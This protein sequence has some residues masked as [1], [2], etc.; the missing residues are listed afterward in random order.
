MEERNLIKSESMPDLLGCNLSNRNPILDACSDQMNKFESK[1]ENWTGARILQIICEKLQNGKIP[2]PKNF[3]L[4]KP[5]EWVEKMKID[6]NFYKNYV[7]D[8][9]D[10]KAFDEL[11]MEL[12]SLALERPI[13]AVHFLDQDQTMTFG[14]RFDSDKKLFIF[15]LN[16][17]L[18]HSFYLSI[19]P[20]S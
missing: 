10:F 15:L 19:F 4:M 20:K 8:G 6:S 13:E 17:I 12:V 7:N 14:Q 11:L 16:D 5:K 2:W 3:H 1:S 9:S 18:D